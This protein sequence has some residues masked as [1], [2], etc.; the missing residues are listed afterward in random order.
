[1]RNSIRLFGR[2]VGIALGHA[3]LDFDRAAH[4]I[5]DAGELDQHAVA[6]G[7]DDTAGM[8]GDLG[9]DQFAAMRLQSRERAF[10]V[11]ADQPAVAG[12]IGREDG[13]QPPLNA[14]V[15]H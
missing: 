8:L 2:H 3:A 1:M 9:I 14:I 15:S 10:L 13:R 12:D 7:L 5:D 6:G 11:V 4:G